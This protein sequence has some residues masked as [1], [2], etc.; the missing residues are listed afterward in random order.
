MPE[1]ALSIVNA[2]ATP[3]V[4]QLYPFLGISAPGHAITT[5]FHLTALAVSSPNSHLAD[6]A[7]YRFRSYPSFWSVA[8]YRKGCANAYSHGALITISSG[9][10]YNTWVAVFGKPLII[11]KIS[12]VSPKHPPLSPRVSENLLVAATRKTHVFCV[13]SVVTFGA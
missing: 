13:H 9:Q 8:E 6:W 11:K 2:L 7:D 5:G 1:N 12:V 4:S 10:H 3:T